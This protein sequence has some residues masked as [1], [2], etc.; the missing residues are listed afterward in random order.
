MWIIWMDKSEPLE[1]IWIWVRSLDMVMINITVLIV[2][3]SA[4][5][6]EDGC[7]LH[8][9][10]LLQPGLVSV[11]GQWLVSHHQT[12][13]TNINHHIPT[14]P[15]LPSCTLD[16]RVHSVHSHHSALLMHP[17]HLHRCPPTL[18]RRYYLIVA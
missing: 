1:Q 18:H 9:L 12:M 11:E 8:Q 17:G 7:V 4:H 10:V 14:I 2:C 5:P 3:L 15:F 6:E 16:H 13:N